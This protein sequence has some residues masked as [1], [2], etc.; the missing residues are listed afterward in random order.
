MKSLGWINVG[1]NSFIALIKC[2]LGYVG[3][4][5]ALFADG[6]HSFGDVMGSIT[7]LLGLKI[8]DRP[9][10]H[11]HP[12]GYGKVEFI[13]AVAIY[14]F[15]FFVGVYI[16]FTAM[17]CILCGAP[18]VPDMVTVIGAIISLAANE[19]M[20]R[21]SYCCG[22]QLSS[23]AMI[24]NAHE[25]RADALSSI[26]VLIGIIGARLGFHFLDPLAAI[27][28]SCFI[29]KLAGT[30]LYK[31]FKGLMDTALSA[32]DQK[33]IMA[34]ISFFPEIIAIQDLR[35]RELG[36]RVSIEVDALIG[37]EKVLGE[38]KTLKTN[39]IQKILKVVNRPGDVTINFIPANK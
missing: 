39:L 7:M 8:A 23:P 3:G 14:T 12:Y 24:A 19:L 25:K 33:K 31:S 34:E 32:E 11:K 16:F 22:E 20:Y 4:S 17:R 5:T 15:L 29:F 35:T 21:Q 6:I 28:V 38:L 10:D 9:K 30:E 26:A 36:Q 13:A 2:F 37:S 27:M 1:G 18:I